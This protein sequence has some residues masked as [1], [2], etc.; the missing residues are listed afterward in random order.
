[1]LLASGGTREDLVDAVAVSARCSIRAGVMMSAR[2]RPVRSAVCTTAC[3]RSLLASSRLCSPCLLARLA[4]LFGSTAR[5]A[6]GALAFGPISAALSSAAPPSAAL[7]PQQICSCSLRSLHGCPVV[8]WNCTTSPRWTVASLL[9]SS[10]MNNCS[11]GR[12]DCERVCVQ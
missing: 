3:S 11:F 6:H 7:T 8:S 4:P 10:R 2:P 1:M 12:I 5:C 9:R